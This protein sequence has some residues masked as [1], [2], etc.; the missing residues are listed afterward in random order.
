MAESHLDLLPPLDVIYGTAGIESTFPSPERLASALLEGSLG[1]GDDKPTYEA[2]GRWLCMRS[3]PLDNILRLLPLNGEWSVTFVL[4]CILNPPG[5]TEEGSC[6]TY[7]ER[8]E[9]DRRRVGLISK[10]WNVFSDWRSFYTEVCPSPLTNLCTQSGCSC[11]YVPRR[12]ILGHFKGA[13]YRE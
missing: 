6:K 4:V 3:V 5:V 12:N 10:Y 2:H 1:V 7:V 11:F 8:A 9:I 13:W